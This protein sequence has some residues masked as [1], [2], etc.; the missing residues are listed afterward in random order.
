M[1]IKDALLSRADTPL[2]RIGLLLWVGAVFVIL[3]T[4]VHFQF[5]GK[6]FVYWRHSS[7][8]F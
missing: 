1:N 3:G 2:K 8:S 7:F 5:D 4:M 6:G